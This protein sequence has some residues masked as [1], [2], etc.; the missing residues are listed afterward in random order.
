MNLIGLNR[1]DWQ[2]MLRRLLCVGMAFLGLFYLY[3]AGTYLEFTH[4][5]MVSWGLL[6]LLIVFGKID[7]F[8]K[9]PWRMI[10][11][12]MALFIALRYWF[13]RSFETLIYTG[14]ADFAAMMAL[15][16]AESYSI[17]IHV[18]GIFISIW[19]LNRKVVPLPGDESALPTVDIFIPTYTEPIDIVRV[20]VAAAVQIDY[21]KEKFRVHILDDGGTIAKRNNP[22]LSD[23]SWERYFSFRQM[24]EEFGVRYIT[25]ETNNHAK[26]GNINHALRQSSGDL[27]LMLDCDHVPTR[28][29]LKNMVGHFIKDKKLALI[30]TPHFFINPDPIEKNLQTFSDA[31]S[32]GEMFYKGIHPGL[33]FWNASYFCGSAAM[34]RRKCLEEV[35]G[36]SLESITEDAETTLHI[37]ARGY[38]SIFLDRPMVCGLSPN[39]FDDFIIQRSRW[40]QGMIQILIIVYPRL[41]KKMSFSQALCYFN[42]CLFW[43]FGFARLLFYIAPAGFLLFG[44][45]VYNAS[46]TQVLVYAIPHLFGSIVLMN[47]LYGKYRWPLFSELYESVQAVFLI[48]PVT[49]VIVNPK[50]PTFKVTPKGANVEVDFLSPFAAPFYLLFILLLIGMP[51]AVYKYFYYPL[52]RDVIAITFCWSSFNLFMALASLGAFFERHQ[53]RKQHR[54]WTKGSGQVFVPRLNKHFDIKLEDLSLTGI[55]FVMPSPCP[56]ASGEDV[57][58]ELTDSYGEHYKFHSRLHRIISRG[59]SFFCG[60]EFIKG[61]ESY[62]KIVRFVYGDS[63]RW[64]ELWERKSKPVSAFHTIFYFIKMGIKGFRESFKGMFALFFAIIRNHITPFISKKFKALRK[65]KGDYKME[66]PET[67]W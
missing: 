15:Y 38:K 51:L 52:Y 45:K 43:F 67:P 48:P 18:L 41:A 39:T 46:V 53:L 32:E 14:P 64:M 2:K 17:T 49:G 66:E 36:M 30:Q 44:L 60:S 59:E 3:L 20:T 65:S 11:L 47:Y 61:K 57:W 1:P 55:G 9:Q 23:H 33:D 7:L 54:V 42:S 10:Y 50:S 22:E 4:Q 28:D 58:L 37:H 12:L 13:W 40:A 35:G 5:I 26:A 8:K 56:L 16:L 27:I 19:P 21:P 29:I 6:G 34:L 31:P 25:R 63:K 24:A 62:S